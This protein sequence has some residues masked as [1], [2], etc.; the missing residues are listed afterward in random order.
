MGLTYL[1]LSRLMH[2]KDA[3]PVCFAMLYSPYQDW[4]APH[5]IS[6]HRNVN[7]IFGH[8]HWRSRCG[9]ARGH[10]SAPWLFKIPIYNMSI[11]PKSEISCKNLI[12]KSSILKHQIHSH[13]NT[14]KYYILKHLLNNNFVLS[15]PRYNWWMWWRWLGEL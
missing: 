5:Y 7:W 14:Y 9:G 15:S 13:S 8:A 10:R 11:L 4:F 1:P 6:S 12:N 3:N 2:V